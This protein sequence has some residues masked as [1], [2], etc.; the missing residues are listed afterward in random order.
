MAA[1]FFASLNDQDAAELLGGTATP[2]AGAEAGGKVDSPTLAAAADAML[3]L[4]GG[5]GETDRL[6]D[7][8]WAASSASASPPSNERSTSDPGAARADIPL[9]RAFSA[10]SSYTLSSETAPTSPLQLGRL[11]STDSTGSLRS[12]PNTGFFA[13]A[14]PMTPAPAPPAPLSLLPA[15]SAPPLPHPASSTL[16]LSFLLIN[17]SITILQPPSS[18]ALTLPFCPNLAHKYTLCGGDPRVIC[19]ANAR[20]AEEEGRPDLAR[21]WLLAASLVLPY[22]VPG[23]RSLHP[24]AKA[25]ERLVA[26]YHQRG[27]I[28]TAA[29]L[30]CVFSMPPQGTA[31]ADREVKVI[32]AAP[33]SF[34]RL[35]PSH[36]DP[37]LLSQHFVQAG[38]AVANASPGLGGLLGGTMLHSRSL[39]NLQAPAADTDRRT[40]LPSP[41]ST[42]NLSSVAT[43]DL[44]P[45]RRSNSNATAAQQHPRSTEAKTRRLFET[46][47]ERGVSGRTSRLDALLDVVPSPSRRAVQAQPSPQQ[48]AGSGN[49]GLPSPSAAAEAAEEEEEEKEMHL[50]GGDT[51]RAL[52]ARMQDAVGATQQR[53]ELLKFTR[54]SPRTLAA[55]A[56]L[57]VD[58][59][60]LPVVTLRRL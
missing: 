5:L 59:V 47:P 9:A 29:L 31:A 26:H 43:A 56:G 20:A 32:V 45:A 49:E 36:S 41:S 3:G 23:P 52:Y 21:T 60:S 14:L 25:A 46:G 44:I 1:S 30:S 18:P 35:P 53:A 19:Q 54:S 39:V 38:A 34:G 40:P 24:V 4:W 58:E 48:P 12:A 28:Q 2:K 13:S 8:F 7:S 42:S 10:D 6:L 11:G 55:V 17:S 37:Y 16:P 57:P 51:L 33:A 50:D 27:D 22:G 15:A